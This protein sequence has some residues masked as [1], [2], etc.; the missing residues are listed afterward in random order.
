MS[1]H[2]VAIIGAGPAGL[3]TALQLQR[4][5]VHA[6]LL[7]GGLVGGL[8][9]NANWVENY[10]GFPGGISGPELVRRFITQA[11]G[12]GVR[13]T[14]E[15]VLSL[16]YSPDPSPS[17]LSGGL[18]SIQTAKQLFQARRVVIASGTRPV[19]LSSVSIPPELMD[20]FSYE[21]YPLL[22]AKGWHIAILGAGD[23]AFDYALNLA[24]SNTVTILNRG[25]R[26]TCLPLLW[27]R[28]AAEAGIEYRPNTSLRRVFATPEGRFGL[29]CATP[30][31]LEQIFAD[32]LLAAIGR[33][34][35]LDF[36]AHHMRQHLA[37]L[38]EQG[39]LYYAGDVKN[40]LYR[41]TAIAVGDGIIAAM[42]IYQS[43]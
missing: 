21:V 24:R 1:L 16:D 41:Q 12:I 39:L 26:V 8:L 22:K 31:D 17:H 27:E 32:A 40:G 15:A 3:A 5:G 37:V 43:L 18:F 25:E 20:R 4:Y 29:E 13:V 34:A 28:A 7:E 42:K 33:E 38:E 14:H 23:A 11:E 10:P 6:L 9:H 30:K 19:P 2:P 35:R 36:I